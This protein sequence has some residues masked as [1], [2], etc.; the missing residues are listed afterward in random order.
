[1][2]TVNRGAV[3]SNLRQY[4]DAARKRAQVEV[5][6]SLER[7]HN[8][9]AALCPYDVQ[10]LDDF[11]MIEHISTRITPGGLGYEAGFLHDDF[12]AEGQEDYFIYTEFGTTKMAAQP[13]VFPA[14]DMEAPR[15]EQALARALE[16]RPGDMR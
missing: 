5:A 12:A 7:M 1:M 15:F 14:R 13:C 16:P 9:I 2:S 3:I 8:H 4:S 10:Q 6:L 11:H